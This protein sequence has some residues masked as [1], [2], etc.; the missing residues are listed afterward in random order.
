MGRQHL[1]AGAIHVRQQKTGAVLEIPAHPEL[2]AILDATPSDNMTFLVTER[3]KPF[4]PGS[5]NN[6]FREW[7]TE[8]GISREYTPH[9]LRRRLVAGSPSWGARPI[10]SWP[11][12]ATGASVRPR[13]TSGRPTSGGLPG[14]L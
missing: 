8:A 4:E 12:A 1:R 7:C 11:S 9:G 13:S 3:G 14:M 5:F 2:L 10:R 6:V